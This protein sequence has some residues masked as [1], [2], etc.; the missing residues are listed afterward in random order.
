MKLETETEMKLKCG[1]K[2]HLQL[3][4]IA[5]SVAK[6][7][8]MKIFKIITWRLGKGCGYGCS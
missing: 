4:L 1:P 5:F 6:G 2:T 8:K 7:N 3:L